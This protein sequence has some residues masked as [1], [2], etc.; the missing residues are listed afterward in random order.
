MGRPVSN[1]VYVIDIPN[2][3]VISTIKVGKKA[4][5]VVVS[6]DGKSVFVTNTMDNTV[7]VIDVASQKVIHTIQQQAIIPNMKWNRARSLSST[8]K[9]AM[10]LH[11]KSYF[12]CF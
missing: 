9:K 10:P 11:T 5:G 2:A 3:K 4:H 7:S 1:E 6:N 8:R 12:G